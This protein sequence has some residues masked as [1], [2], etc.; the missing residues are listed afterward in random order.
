MNLV[1]LLALWFNLIDGFPYKYVM[2]MIANLIK[3]GTGKLMLKHLIVN[4]CS[5]FRSGHFKMTLGS[6]CF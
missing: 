6:D 1:F 5:E 2:F 4:N 3:P